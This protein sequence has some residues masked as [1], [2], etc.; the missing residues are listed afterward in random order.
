VVNEL[1]FLKGVFMNFIPALFMFLLTKKVLDFMDN[2]HEINKS[3]FNIHHSN[4]DDIEILKNKI[5]P[6]KEVENGI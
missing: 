2:Q 4:I 3:N 5:S 6:E 1:Q